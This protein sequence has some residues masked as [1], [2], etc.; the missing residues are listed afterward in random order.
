MKSIPLGAIGMYTFCQKF[1][2]GLQQLMAGSRKFKVSTITR[3]DLVALTQ[4]AA[5][6]SGIPYVV[7]AHREEAERILV[8][9]VSGTFSDQWRYDAGRIRASDSA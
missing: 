3:G 6:V 8:G 4:E 5:R 7:D 2:V 1:K 9:D